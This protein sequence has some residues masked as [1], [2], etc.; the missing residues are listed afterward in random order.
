MRFPQR[1]RSLSGRTGPSHQ[2]QKCFD[3][4]K[5]AI[6]RLAFFIGESCLAKPAQPLRSVRAA[7]ETRRH[8]DDAIEFRSAARVG[9]GITFY[10]PA[11]LENSNCKI[12][13]LC[14]GLEG[15]IKPGVA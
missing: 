13:I 1:Y 7:G 3:R 6:E 2:S 5:R 10:E 15:Q 9:I 12:V 14:R 4:G 11:R 8:R